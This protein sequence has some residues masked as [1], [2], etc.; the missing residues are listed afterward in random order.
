MT[1]ILLLSM[2]GCQWARTPASEETPL[3]RYEYAQLHMGVQV[4]LIVY[5]ASEEVAKIACGAA[6]DRI[7]QL[8]QIMSDYRFDSEVMQLCAHPP[9]EAV[10]VSDELMFV[11]QRAQALSKR[12][13]SA[14][15][16][17]VGPMV[18]LW[19]IAR[20]TGEMP[21]P[22]ALANAHSRVGWRHVSLDADAGTVTLNAP[23]MR[24]DFGGI[25]KGYAG[26]EAIRV[27]KSR[28]IRS[29]LFEAGGD[30]VVSDAPPGKKGW[31]IEV[32]EGE[33]HPARTLILKN[34]AVST[35]GATEQ[36]VTID[37]K[38]Y[39]HVVDPR[40]GIGLTNQYMATVIAPR[41]ITAD[42]LS[43]AVTVLGSQR[44]EKLVKRYRGTSV[45]T[46]KVL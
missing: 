11:L 12:S 23:N 24:L 3:Q 31:P 5:A 14:F 7:A 4:R 38:N 2:A 36:F 1:V 41:G 22:E 46:R 19:R 15:D 6:Y 20:K 43:T 40:T 13:G 25:G 34:A 45:Y 32:Y 37:G 39:S 30:I 8:E 18:Q 26:D 9:G 35:S 10:K 21:T 16:V 17:T 42:G 29:A 33:H 27:L 28:G 44:G